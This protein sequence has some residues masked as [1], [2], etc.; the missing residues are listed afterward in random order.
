MADTVQ[1]MIQVTHPTYITTAGHA[2]G[3]SIATNLLVAACVL[4]LRH[5]LPIY[6]AVFSICH[7]FCFVPI[8]VALFIMAP[9]RSAQEVFIKFTDYTGSWP[10]LGLSVLT[11]QIPNIY[12][13]LNSAA[14]VRS[15]HTTE[16]DDLQL[17]N[18]TIW[19]YP[20]DAGM[21]VLLAILY[22]FS[23]VSIPD[24]LTYKSAFVQVFH[25]AFNDPGPT[26]AFSMVVLGLIF[27]IAISSMASAAEQISNIAEQI[28]LPSRARTWLKL[29][30][31]HMAILTS[32]LLTIL[33]SF[34]PLLTPS[35]F[36]S[37]LSLAIIAQMSI[38]VLA[39]STRVHDKLPAT[40]GSTKGWIIVIDALALLYAVWAIF[41][42]LSPSTYK[43]SVSEVNWAGVILVVLLALGAGLW[44][45]TAKPTYREPVKERAAEQRQ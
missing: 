32:L 40:N 21:T 18:S 33:L 35:A 45:W 9:K 27:M 20:V 39:I 13:A 44:H 41:W 43:P 7:Y 29:S 12:V 4:L 14:I 17:S 23:V 28:T 25:T 26:L 15:P 8:L 10:N 42:A 19:G 1:A 24:A 5:H 6:E 36:D 16:Q 2:I 22:C 3:L 37:I 30:A 11:G 38:V 31:S 34:L